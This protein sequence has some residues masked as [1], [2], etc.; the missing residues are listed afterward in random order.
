MN[1]E[2]WSG[3][4]DYWIQDGRDIKHLHIP[5]D[6]ADALGIELPPKEETDMTDDA[7]ETTDTPAA[8][9]PTEDNLFQF[10]KKKLFDGAECGLRGC[11]RKLPIE[12]SYISGIKP[13]KGGGD[14]LW[15]GPACVECVTQAHSGLTPDTLAQLAHQRNGKSDLALILDIEVGDVERRLAAAGTDE[16]GRPLEA[17][18][19]Q[20]TTMGNYVAGLTP[21]TGEF[22]AQVQPTAIPTDH[23]ATTS[24]KTQALL[25]DLG[26]WH[27]HDQ[28]GMDWA[29]VLL[30]GK[31]GQRNPDDTLVDPVGDPDVVGIKSQWKDLDEMRKAL[32]KPYRDKTA[33]IQTHF[34]P[35]LNQLAQAEGIIKQ[36]ISEGQQ[37][38]NAAQQAALQQAQA[39]HAVG[40]MQAAGQAA[41]QVAAT[42]V[43][44]PQG[45]HQRQPI[46]NYAVMD[47]NAVP[48]EYWSV[49]PAKIQAG[50][51]RGVRQIPGVRIWEE[52]S[53]Q[54]RQS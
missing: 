4:I 35:V 17:S 5:Q 30:N 1:T 41:Q 33:E 46:V 47:P 27:I 28:V 6:V 3:L 25:V 2:E 36:K 31:K 39:A 53:L 24:N 34:N 42:D 13:T 38:A 52:P 50:L 54:A 14:R 11:N 48:A 43:A 19:I 8:T 9:E 40:N 15:Y 29:G 22:L 44:L 16:N 32:G 7:T 20:Q 45:V 21:P 49:D 23:L 18:A 37:R 26:A 12:G 51:A 10:K